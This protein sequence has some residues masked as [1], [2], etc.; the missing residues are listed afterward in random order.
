MTRVRKYELVG[1][2]SRFGVRDFKFGKFR[3]LPLGLP[4]RRFEFLVHRAVFLAKVG[5]EHNQYMCAAREVHAETLARG[6]KGPDSSQ[7]QVDL[8]FPNLE[9]LLNYPRE[10][11]EYL[12]ETTWELALGLCVDLTRADCDWV[13]NIIEEAGLEDQHVFLRCMAFR[14]LVGFDAATSY[15]VPLGKRFVLLEL[16]TQIDNAREEFALIVHSDDHVVV[17]DPQVGTRAGQV[18]DEV[19][20]GGF[21]VGPGSTIE[22]KVNRTANWPGPPTKIWARGY[23]EET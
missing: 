9:E 2:S 16:S 4:V 11:G 14:R 6:E 5:P 13:I 18:A 8:G 22:V 12:S 7:W 21:A 1:D 23:L 20:G 17:R 19:H 10:C 3:D 15:V